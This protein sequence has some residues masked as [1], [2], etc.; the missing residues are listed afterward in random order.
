MVPALR[1]QAT[2]RCSAGGRPLRMAE[3][4]TQERTMSE[5][6][7]VDALVLGSGQGGKLL[8]WHMAR[9]GQRTAVVERRYIGGSCPNIACMPSKNEVWSARVANFVRHAAEFGATVGSVATDMVKV[10]QRKREMV[11]REVALHLKNYRE[12]GAELIM[13]SGRF[14]RP[15]MLE[16]QLNDGGTRLLM[17]EQVFLNLGSH[18]AIPAIPGLEASRP[19]TH[20]EAL[21][22]DH[23][24]RHLI[25]LGGGYVGLEMAQAFRRFGSRVT[26]IE[27]GSQLMGREDPD[28]ADT[29][30]RILG[31]E[32]VGLLLSAET[33]NVR[34]RSGDEVTL[35][36][37]TPTGDAAIQGSDILVAAGRIPN[38]AGIGLEEAGVE[39]DSRGYIRVNDRLETTAPKV[40]ALGECAGSPQFTHVS[41]DDFRVIVDNQAGAN[42][43]TRDRLVPYCMFTDPPLA[44]VG[45]SEGDAQRLGITVRVATLPMEEVLRTHTTGEAFGFMKVL[46]SLNDDRILG[47][48]MIGSEAGEVMAAVQTAMLANLPYTTLR[49]AVI[50][51][52]T[53][54][55]GLGSLLAGVPSR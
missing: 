11:E 40:W 43:S 46:V 29:M 47:F 14:V 49:D 4:A 42:R 18:A 36:V 7:R 52:L 41:V 10:R 25:I 34:G 3:R 38:T 48:T 50:A 27:A 13:G 54:A 44:H 35:T 12:S 8:A 2:L 23:V 9:A 30:Q 31:G 28:V 26:V 6:E 53:I 55:E 33:L 37:R 22:L 16:V 1:G 32:G 21:E 17:A 24:P 39:L 20:I 19:L 15:R 5:A 45:L 51:H